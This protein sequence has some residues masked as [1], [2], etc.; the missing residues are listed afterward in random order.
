MRTLEYLRHHRAHHR[1][2]PIPK[3]ALRRD[4]QI[5]PEHRRI[6]AQHE[7]RQKADHKA[8][9]AD[10]PHPFPAD[11][12]GKMAERDLAGHA[13]QTDQPERPGRAVGRKA[14]LLQ[15]FRLVHLHRVPGVQRTEIPQRQPPEPRGAHGAPQRPVGRG[16]NRVDD[17]GRARRRRRIRHAVPIRPQA[18]ILRPLAQ[19][20]VDRRQHDQDQQSEH[21]ARLAPAGPEDRRL[22]PRQQRDG[23]Q[24]HAGEGQPDGQAA[25]AHEPVGQ[26]ERLPGIPQAHAAPADQHP[27]GQIEVPRLGRERR[28]QE[29]GRHQYRAQLHH[30]ARAEAVHHPPDQRAEDA[31]DDETERKRAGRYAA[32]PVE[33][34]EDGR[35]QQRERGAGVHA[36]SHRH[37]RDGDDDPAIEERH[38]HELSLALA[39]ADR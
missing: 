16:P 32:I 11:P 37:E 20:Q 19:Q 34:V 9:I 36:D 17:I 3:P 29:A 21:P 15:V 6:V 31:G 8:Q 28:Q 23:T 30:R 33:L 12:I 27:D 13:D 18:Q 22:H 1:R 4:H 5:E 10:R 14:D 39:S 26:I 38:P 25:A 35:K 24:A 2:Q 7:Q